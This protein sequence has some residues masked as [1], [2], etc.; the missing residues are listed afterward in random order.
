M[1]SARRLGQ[2]CGLMT[3]YEADTAVEPEPEPQ[4]EATREPLVAPFAGWLVR[5]EWADRVIS[6]AYDNLSLT[7]RRAIAA[8][9]PYSYV[10]VTRSAEDLIGDEGY[11]LSKL[12]RLGSAALTRLL[13]ADVFAPTG[14]P[15]LYLYRMV[16]ERGAQT[17]VVCTVAVQGIS[18]RRIRLHENV[19]DNHTAMLTEHLCGVGAAS[20]PVALAVSDGADLASTMDD[21]TSAAPPELLFGSSLVHHEVWTVPAASTDRL[22]AL[23]EGKVLYVTDGH[24]RLNAAQQALALEPGNKTLSRVLAAIYPAEQMHVE[25]F[26]RIVV[27]R[28][29]TR[30]TDCLAAIEAVAE[31]IEHVRT[32]R[33]ARPTQR[34]QVGVYV[35]G[36]NTWHRMT[37]PPAPTGCA[38]VEAL[39]VELLR[40]QVLDPVLGA[41][42]LGGRGAVD[43][44][45]DTAGITELVHRCDTENRVGFVLHPV[46][47]DELTLVA[48]EDGRMPPKSSFFIPKPRSGALMYMLGLGAT[49]GLSPSF[50]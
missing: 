23:L 25:A 29:H 26:H 14:R 43:Y 37:L 32:P 15:A 22:L 11:S 16:H 44:L 28:Y 45:P 10:N 20:N 36:S 40:R 47:V 24:H 31:R 49:A 8:G 12:V 9:N 18:D 3:D 30:Q 7:Q 42:E 38:A 17:G 6:R 4:A 41:D 21:I 13:D 34:G 19:R 2:A 48:D 33:Q 35:G 50:P 1:A 46:S 27:D 5:P 39:D